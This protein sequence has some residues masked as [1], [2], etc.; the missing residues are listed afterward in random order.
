MEPGEIGKSDMV[1]DWGRKEDSM[2]SASLTVEKA[3]RKIDVTTDTKQATVLF[4]PAYGKVTLSQQSQVFKINK[5]IILPTYSLVWD[6][7]KKKK[8]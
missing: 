6:T 5:R 3:W 8:G 7:K 1:R 4:L 2:P